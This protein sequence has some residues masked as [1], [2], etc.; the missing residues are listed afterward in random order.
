M[1]SVKPVIGIG[2]YPRTVETAFGPT[3]LHTASRHYVQAVERAGGA[4]VVLPVT[5]SEDEDVASVLRV[6]DG[7]VLTGGG[8]IQPSMYGEP[9]DNSTHGVN[10]ERDAFEVALFQQ[11]VAAELPVLAICRG[12]QLMNVAMGGSLV[13]DVFSATG[14]FHDE[15][16]R[17]HELVHGIKVE[18]G[19]CLAETLGVVQLGVNSVH[20][21]GIGRLATDLRAVAW[22]EDG[23]IEGVEL[24]GARFALGVQ[25][26]PE[27]LDDQP[28]QQGLFR[29][30]VDQARARM[31]G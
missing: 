1:G 27:M 29:A 2:A 13:Q 15:D 17:A 14:Q 24:P 16:K 7:V 20:H 8:D 31:T 25:W 9:P 28:E 10:A 22:A 3:L 23:S 21:Q 6:L 30:L 11:A 4:P 19:S 12:M 18:P 5:E 26:H